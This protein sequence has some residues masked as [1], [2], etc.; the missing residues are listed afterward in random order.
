MRAGP[1]SGARGF[2]LTGLLLVIAGSALL[3]SWGIPRLLAPRLEQNEES[4]RRHLEMLDGLQQAWLLR[5]SW[6]ASLLELSTRGLPGSAE[7]APPAL[8]E[9]WL[10]G[11]EPAGRVLRGGYLFRDGWTERQPAGVWA[12]PATPGYSGRRVYWLDYAT[13]R[14]HRVPGR[15]GGGEPPAGPPEVGELQPLD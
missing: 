1:C 2:H 7:A 11:L 12:W 14:I 5:R 8:G 6:P 13:H 3:A 15:E 9:G 10:G 4:A